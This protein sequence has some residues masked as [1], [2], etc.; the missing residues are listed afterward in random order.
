MITFSE[1]Q[2][3]H[4]GRW[5]MTWYSWDLLGFA[6]KH[7]PTVITK[8]PWYLL[9]LFMEEIPNNHRLHVQ[10]NP[11]K[12]KRDKH[13]SAATSTGLLRRISGWTINPY[14]FGIEGSPQVQ[15]LQL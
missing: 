5:R 1:K 14:I 3:H 4:T 2:G 13:C 11:R 9:K 6:M 10:T 15:S 8:K 12:K 7:L